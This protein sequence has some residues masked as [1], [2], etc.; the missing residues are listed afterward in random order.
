MHVPASLRGLLSDL[1]DYAGLFPPAGL[2]MLQTVQNYA[3]Y[4]GGHE[5]WMLARFVLP[6][7]RFAEFDTAF[8]HIEP[9]EPWGITAL[10][11]DDAA[12]DLEQ[13]AA[14][15][16][17]HDEQAAV[18]AIEI[19]AST[20]EEISHIRALVRGT[21]TAF[22]EIP[23]IDPAGN[24][25][26]I[27][28]LRA[29]AKIRTGGVTVEALPASE[30]VANFLASA[31]EIGVP[32]KATAGL[33]HPVRCLKPLTYEA[34]A[35]SGTM[36]GFLNVFLAACFAQRNIGRDALVSLLED[37]DPTH[38]AFDDTG[39]R[40]RDRTLTTEQI[41]STRER[42]AISFGSCSFE[43][44]LAELRELKFL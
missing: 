29:H 15:N 40:W 14:F 31:A 6:V 8:A 27:H 7:S 20:L 33:H 19:K 37:T 17:R 13:I 16:T 3:H 39:A 28:D 2:P 35:A 9:V 43:E 38:F 42:F 36:H 4:L 44:P 10:L 23:A 5:A 24:L 34:N 12:A 18:D 32:F 41:R 25:K 22:F 1:I 30:V 26:A 21:I 11:G